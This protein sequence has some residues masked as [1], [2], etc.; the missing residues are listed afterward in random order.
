M[1]ELKK[2]LKD[3]KA[4]KKIYENNIFKNYKRLLP[5]RF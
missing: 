1:K 2:Q 3:L 4:V 5:K